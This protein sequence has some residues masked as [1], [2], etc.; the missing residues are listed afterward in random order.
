MVQ[1]SNVTVSLEKTPPPY[2]QRKERQFSGAMDE[3]AR[4]VQKASTHVRGRVAADGAS[5]KGDGAGADVDAAT[6]HSEKEMSI[7]RGNGGNVQ[8]SSE[9]E[10][11]H[12]QLTEDQVGVA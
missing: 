8:E 9:S 10:C 11:V 7:Q 4:K 6:L 12:S 1:E 2:I 5:V 3:R